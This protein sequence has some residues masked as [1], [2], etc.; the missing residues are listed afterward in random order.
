M[1]AKLTT[2][3][4]PSEIERRAQLLKGGPA[5]ANLRPPGWSSRTRPAAR[6]PAVPH[7]HAPDR[8]RQSSTAERNRA[9]TTRNPPGATAPAVRAPAR[10]DTVS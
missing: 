7:P 4:A 10:L 1:L 2:T 8:A 3:P 6:A 9:Q 5:V